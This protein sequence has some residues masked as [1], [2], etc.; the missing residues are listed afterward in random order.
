[1]ILWNYKLSTNFRFEDLEY[2]QSIP[3]DLK[4]LPLLNF[5]KRILK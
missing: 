4:E 2:I 3:I 5:E 1:M